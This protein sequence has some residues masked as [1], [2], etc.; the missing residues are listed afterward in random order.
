MNALH[1]AAEGNDGNA[2]TVAVLLDAGMAVESRAADGS[3]PLIIASLNGRTSQ[4][5]EL[6]ARGA[7][8]DAVNTWG[9]TPLMAVA[10]NGSPDAVKA[11]LDADPDIDAQDQA[12]R[13][14]L[15]YS[16]AKGNGVVTAMIARRNPN[17]NIADNDGW[18]P[19]HMARTMSTLDPL[20]RMGADVNAR[21]GVTQY[22]DWT[23]LMFAS[24]T[25]NTFMVRCLVNADADPMIETEEQVNAMRI[26]LALEYADGSNPIAEIL[27]E[28]VAKRQAVEEAEALRER[29]EQRLNPGSMP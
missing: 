1:W 19:I 9:L 26:A 27:R 15:H 7:D 3:T 16:V 2:E 6:L 28:A 17:P 4:I 11:I 29:Q 25:G 10:T 5:V 13:V 14:A 21:C 8:V 23:P 12:G 24:A 20:V 22:P 18:M